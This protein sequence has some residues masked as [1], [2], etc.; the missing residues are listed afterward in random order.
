MASRFDEVE[1]STDQLTIPF[2]SAEKGIDELSGIGKPSQAEKEQH[3]QGKTRELIAVWLLGLLCAVVA[4]AFTAY[5]VDHDTTDPKER[6]A[7]L[8]TLLDV[9]VGPIITL[10]SSA[11]GFYFG[12]RTAQVSAA[13]A[14]AANSERRSERSDSK[15]QPPS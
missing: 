2:V 14:N 15:Q 9:L 5:F 13:A 7:Q 8:K 4:L 3:A 10:L 11:I 1:K 6:F 12:S